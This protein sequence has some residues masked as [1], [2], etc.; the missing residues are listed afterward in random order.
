MNCGIEQDP[1]GSPILSFQL[2]L[3]AEQNLFFEQFV[4]KRLALG[5]VA[6]KL[7]RVAS[8]KF[9]FRLITKNPCSTIVAIQQP[10]IQTRDA[11]A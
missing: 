7:R 8:T 3:A 6:I 5:W 9:V 4:H 11:H 2:Q 10:S 1:N